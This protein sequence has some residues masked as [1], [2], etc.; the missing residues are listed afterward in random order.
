[1][2]WVDLFILFI[3]ISLVVGTALL[4]WIQ[5]DKLLSRVEEKEEEE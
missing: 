1:M 4:L 2:T 5:L 3:L